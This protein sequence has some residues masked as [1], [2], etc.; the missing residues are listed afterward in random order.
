MTTHITHKLSTHLPDL[1]EA[2]NG[3]SDLRKNRK[4]FKKVYKYYKDLGVNFSGDDAL[5]YDTLLD[6]LY[7]DVF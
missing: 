3:S 7:E 6:C 2:V 1:R 4:L 5:D